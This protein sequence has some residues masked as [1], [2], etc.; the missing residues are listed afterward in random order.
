MCKADGGGG[1]ERTHPR[2]FL[3]SVGVFVPSH[4]FKAIGGCTC[5]FFFL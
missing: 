5:D 1:Q 4:S 2:G 3:L